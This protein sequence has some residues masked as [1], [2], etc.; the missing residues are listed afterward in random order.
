M[1]AKIRGIVKKSNNQKRQARM[2]QHRLSL[3]KTK[4]L[5]ARDDLT[6]P[7]IL[8]SHPV[9]SY[10][11]IGDIF[12]QTMSLSPSSIPSSYFDDRLSLM[13]P[14]PRTPSDEQ[15]PS[16]DTEP[17]AGNVKVSSKPIYPVRADFRESTSDSSP[18]ED[19]QNLLMHYLDHVFPLQF[20]FYDPS[21]SD[22]GRGWLL[23]ILM[24]TKP[25]YHAALT[26]AAYHQQASL[27]PALAKTE[28]CTLD[29]L[30]GHHI[31]AVR[32]LRRY[33]N[34]FETGGRDKSVSELIETLASIALLVSLEVSPSLNCSSEEPMFNRANYTF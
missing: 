3:N 1:A 34:G 16:W 12:P 13:I 25:L 4:A 31:L 14:Q 10:G 20:R 5:N 32:E 17:E 2:Q 15:G 33:L 27:C 22:G 24:R 28:R 30:L 8:S 23:S 6:A 18:S 19:E 26:L 29:E 7:D 21:I 9:E 11:D